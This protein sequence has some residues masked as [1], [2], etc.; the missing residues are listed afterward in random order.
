MRIF[1]VPTAAALNQHGITLLTKLEQAAADLAVA[2]VKEDLTRWKRGQPQPTRGLQR[3]ITRTLQA[4]DEEW[5]LKNA[6]EAQ[7][8]QL[9]TGSGKAA[10]APFRDPAGEEHSV[11]DAC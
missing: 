1:G 5:L 11:E 7:R 4:Q 2:G 3:R 8:L 6:P 9:R 10:A